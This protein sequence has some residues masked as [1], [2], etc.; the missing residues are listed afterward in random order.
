MSRRAPLRIDVARVIDRYLGLMASERAPRLR[1]LY[2]VGS[3]A[4]GDFRPGVS[5][6]DFVALLDA[7]PDGPDL[8]ALARVH[9]ALAAVGGPAFDGLYLRLE[10][11]RRAPDPAARI[12]FSLGGCLRRDEPCEAANPLLWRCLARAGRPI[13][14]AAPAALGIA[15]DDA[16]LRA[17]CL[18]RLDQAWRPWIARIETALGRAPE[19]DCDAA[20]LAQGVLGVSRLVCTLTTG[21]VVSKR[22]GGRF[23]LDHLPEAHRP[24]VRDA[25]DARDG[26]LEYVSPARMHAALD[27][28]RLLI[29]GARNAPLGA[30][31]PRSPVR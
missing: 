19:A 16:P 1:G 11:V 20:V 7:P 13:L 6:I 12:P 23:V 10:A 29:D 28:M 30:L 21:R 9:A 3:V 27:T 4:L 24:A 15:D 5:G 25:L 26:A 14:G 8:D 2:L 18:D 17:H 31:A 22:E